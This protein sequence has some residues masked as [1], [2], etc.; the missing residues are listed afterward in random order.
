ML[1]VYIM[2]NELD[3]INKIKLKNNEECNKLYSKWD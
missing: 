2:E 1:V 3:K